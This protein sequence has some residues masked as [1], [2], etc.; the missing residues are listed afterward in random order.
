M[1][2]EPIYFKIF[3]DSNNVNQCEIRANDRFK[4][5]PESILAATITDLIFIS[6]EINHYRKHGIFTQKVTTESKGDE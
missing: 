2:I 6:V 4:V 1:Y 5:F 3:I